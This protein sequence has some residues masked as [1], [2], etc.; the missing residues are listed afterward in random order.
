MICAVTKEAL[1]A[2]SLLA[3][4]NDVSM[5]ER[6]LGMVSVDSVKRVV[7]YVKANHEVHIRKRALSVQGIDALVKLESDRL[8]VVE[9]WILGTLAHLGLLK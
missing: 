2:D 9:V 7:E 8:K 3:F 5:A 6:G 4:I 1:L